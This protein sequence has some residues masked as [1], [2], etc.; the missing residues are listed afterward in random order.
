MQDEGRAGMGAKMQTQSPFTSW[1]AARTPT[2]TPIINCL[3][4]VIIE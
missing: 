3:L 2:A 1:L 4:Q